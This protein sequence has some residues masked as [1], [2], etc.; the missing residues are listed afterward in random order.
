MIW[1]FRNALK[2]ALEIGCKQILILGGLRG[3]FW[4]FFA[5]PGGCKMDFRIF[6]NFP[7]GSWEGPRSDLFYLEVFFK[8]RRDPV[9][10]FDWLEWLKRL[11]VDFMTISGWILRLFL[12]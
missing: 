6:L 5:S 2:I 4:V 7:F 11:Q 8:L 1:G 3:R 9:F 12:L 10:G